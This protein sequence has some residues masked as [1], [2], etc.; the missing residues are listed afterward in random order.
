M[1]YNENWI[2]KENIIDS[3]DPVRM[4]IDKKVWSKSINGINL[5]DILIINNWMNYANAIGDYSYKKIFGK[6]IK[7][8]LINKIL[9]K[10]IE[11]RKKEV[12][13]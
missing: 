4:E 5:S 2:E 6:K 1:K 8:S 9:D 3:R 7:H 12:S 10:Q 13:I 11:F